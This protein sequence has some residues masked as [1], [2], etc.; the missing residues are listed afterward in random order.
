MRKITTELVSRTDCSSITF[1]ETSWKAAPVGKPH[2]GC[3]A[4]KYSAI[5]LEICMLHIAAS[6]Q[7]SF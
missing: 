7:F 3:V 5:I 1:N 4:F 2:D 6:A